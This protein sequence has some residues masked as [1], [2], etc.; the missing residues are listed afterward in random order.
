MWTMSFVMEVEVIEQ[1]RSRWHS[2]GIGCG[3]DWAEVESMDSENSV[4]LVLI[5]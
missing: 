5:F 4:Q 2:V 1:R 3:V